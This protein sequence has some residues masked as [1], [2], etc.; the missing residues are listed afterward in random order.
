MKSKFCELFF[1]IVIVIIAGFSC[2]KE[3]TDAPFREEIIITAYLYVDCTIDS[4]YVGKSLQI[5]EIYDP[6]KA[7]VSGA[8]LVIS[9]DGRDFPLLEY[10][11]NPGYYYEPTKELI[12]TPGKEYRLEGQIDERK[13]T[14]TTT[15][16]E[17]VRIDSI[18]VPETSYLGREFKIYWQNV[19][20]AAGYIVTSIAGPSAELVELSDF[21]EH[22]FVESEYDTL[23]FFPKVN[24][25]PVHTMENIFQIPWPLFWYYGEHTV[26]LYAVD[27]NLW[28]LS[29]STTILGM[30]SSFFEKP[31]SHIEGAIGVFAA[32]SKS[33]VT[34]FVRRDY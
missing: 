9:V 22:A 7:T 26:V 30:Q 4:V 3:P 33:S 12:I 10:A 24:H 23:E 11:D 14:S 1:F 25:F 6:E 31:P 28:E 21:M 27:K 5:G 15:A 32:L 8:N 18:N 2:I 13:V 29:T 20:G 17:R 16:P 34:V 19:P